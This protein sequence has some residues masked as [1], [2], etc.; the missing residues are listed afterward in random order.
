MTDQPTL[1][2]MLGQ[3]AQ[4]KEVLNGWDAVLN[5]L[6]SSINEFLQSQYQAYTNNSGKMVIAQVFCGPAVKTSRGT[7]STVT[8]FSFTLGAPE[9]LFANGKNQVTVTQ[10]IESGT[11]RSGSLEVSDNFNPNQCGGVKDDSRVTWGPEKQIDVGKNPSITAAVELTS[12]TGIINQT[13]HTLVLDFAQGAFTA[14]NITIENVTSTEL[15]D[16]I[17]NWFMNNDVKYQVAS[18]DFGGNTMAAL[19]PTQIQFHVVQTNAGN[20]IVQILI[21]T[22]GSIGTGMP[23]VTEPIPTADGYTCTLMINSRIVFTNILCDG[24][25]KAGKQFNIYPQCNSPAQGYTAYIAPQM[26]FAGSFSYGSCC[27]RTTVTYSLYLGGTYSGTATQGFHLYQSITPSG[28]VGNT[29][30]V[31][32]YNPLTLSG[33]KESQKIHITPQTPNI[34]VTGGAS[35]TINSKLKDILNNDFSAAMSGIS[36][37][38][39]TYFALRNVLFPGNLMSMSVVQVPTDLVIVGKFESI[40]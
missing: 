24:F 8:E 35:G 2:Y 40:S 7:F 27:D 33:S 16:Q 6:E 15:S 19:T 1:S 13:T 28:N 39:V 3:M 26:H 9:F 29:I 17:K 21:V 5:V 22:N 14:N 18:I 31:N 36:F 10:A 20:I 23:I 12:V 37:N 11:T 32:G 34:T 25:N 4:D 38:D 30:T